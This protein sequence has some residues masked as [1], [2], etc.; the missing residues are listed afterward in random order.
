MKTDVF[1]TL[2]SELGALGVPAYIYASTH[3]GPPHDY[4][5]NGKVSLQ[6]ILCN[7]QKANGQGKHPN[8]K[9]RPTSTVETEAMGL[10][11]WWCFWEVSNLC[12]LPK[13]DRIPI[14]KFTAYGQTKSLPSGFVPRGPTIVKGSFIP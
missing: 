10:E 7:F 8:P 3:H 5:E 12:V 11:V 6:G 4:A 2:L 1:E 13:K 14:T 9:Y